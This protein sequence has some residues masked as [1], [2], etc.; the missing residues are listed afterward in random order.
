M[1]VMPSFDPHPGETM[2]AYFVRALN[3]ARRTGTAVS[4]VWGT[5]PLT[6]TPTMTPHSVAQAWMAAKRATRGKG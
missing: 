1:S 5:Q 4:V 2:A 3:D 6:I